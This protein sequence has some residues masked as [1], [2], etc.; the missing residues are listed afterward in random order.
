MGVSGELR[1]PGPMAKVVLGLGLK[2]WPTRQAWALGDP[3]NI[4]CV[5]TLKVRT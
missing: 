1:S 4:S 5:A 2:I 3:Q